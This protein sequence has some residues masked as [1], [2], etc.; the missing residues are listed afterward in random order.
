MFTRV[1]KLILI[2]ALSVS[3]LTACG[4]GEPPLPDPIITSVSPDKAEPGEKVTVLG[5]N[6][7]NV[8]SN[9]KVTI[10]SQVGSVLRA[11]PGSVTFTVP[12]SLD[13]KEY[14]LLTELGGRKSNSK[15]FIVLPASPT[16]TSVSTNHGPFGTEVVLQGNNFGTDSS[17]IKV[18]IGS[19][20]V[21]VTTVSQTGM[22]FTI[23]KMAA[24]K[25]QMVVEVNSKSINTSM[26]DVE[27][28][29]PGDTNANPTAFAFT[30]VNGAEPGS[31]ISSNEITIGGLL[32]N[33]NASIS[34]QGGEYS[35][36]DSEPVTQAFTVT[37][38]MRVKVF[39]RASASFDVTSKVTL[40]IGNKTSTFSIKTRA[41]RRDPTGWAN[42]V[43]NEKLG[44]INGAKVSSD[45]FVVTGMEAA[46]SISILGSDTGAEFSVDGGASW[47]TVDS[48]VNNGSTVLARIAPVS[49]PNS[50]RRVR[51]GI[52]GIVKDFVVRTAS[53]VQI[54]TN[55]VDGSMT[56]TRTKNIDTGQITYST[57]KTDTRLTFRS[58]PGS[59][60]AIISGYRITSAKIGS[61]PNLISPTNPIVVQ[62]LNVYIQAGFTCNPLPSKYLSCLIGAVGYAPASGTESDALIVPVPTD[63]ENYMIANNSAANEILQITLTGTDSLGASVEI[64][65]PEVVF[66][67]I[68]NVAN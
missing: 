42:F 19:E 67:G 45:S 65:L 6:F 52:Q 1:F 24:G 10:G 49:S 16:V 35:I 39:G 26:F 30:N 31:S 25:Y 40:R 36:N 48:T 4:G 62:G 64:P 53:G 14:E 66:I 54:Q 28:A 38:N 51:I 8:S 41:L 68:Y 59:L 58:V 46:G 47:R 3:V 7:G 11:E 21:N 50:T 29:G 27:D 56:V 23:P 60:E 63:L 33:Q 5:S 12:S 22:R 61:S 2:G 43:F 13:A 57:S 9:I 20:P 17:R 15:T 34:I 55:K 44:E 18:T 37:N 32:P